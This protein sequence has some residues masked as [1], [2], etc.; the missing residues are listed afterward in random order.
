M[1]VIYKVRDFFKIANGELWNLAIK[2][3]KST[4][5]HFFKLFKEFIF[6][7]VVEK[8]KGGLEY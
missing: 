6:L 4:Y 5:I 3:L 1:Y 2:D 7:L 8:E